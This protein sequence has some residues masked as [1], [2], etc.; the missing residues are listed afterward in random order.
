MTVFVCVLKVHVCA[1]MLVCVSV[2]VC[3][4]CARVCMCVHVCVHPCQYVVQVPMIMG[5]LGVWYN[6]FFGAQSHALLPYDQVCSCLFDIF[7]ARISLL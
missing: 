2:C 5:M 6:N 1:C 4:L 7:E 3:G